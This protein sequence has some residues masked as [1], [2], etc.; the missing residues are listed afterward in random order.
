MSDDEAAR[1]FARKLFGPT[2]DQRRQDAAVLRAVHGMNVEPEPELTDSPNFDG[3]PR[4]PVGG[5]A[6]FDPRPPLPAER[7]P[8]GWIEVEVEDGADLLFPWLR[9]G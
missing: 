4:E 7:T 3:G 1:E 2:R 5:H 8:D 9:D 6:R